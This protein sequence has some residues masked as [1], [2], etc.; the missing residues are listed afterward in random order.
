MASPRGGGVGASWCS[1]GLSGPCGGLSG[2]LGEIPMVSRRA[3]RDRASWGPLGALRGPL[4]ASWNAREDVVRM[5][6]L[7][8]RLACRSYKEPLWPLDREERSGPLGGLLG[9]LGGLLGRLRSASEDVMRAGVLFSRL[10][11]RS[12]RRLHKVSRRGGGV[13]ASWRPLG[14][15]WGFSGFFS[16]VLECERRRS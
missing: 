1:W 10:V 2:R 6:V 4:G 16:G 12:Y 15:S 7:L 3:G 13:R 8:S 14:A 9:P 5:R 11:C